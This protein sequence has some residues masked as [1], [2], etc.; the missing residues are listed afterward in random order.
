MANYNITS[1]IS[2]GTVI[3]GVVSGGQIIQ[4]DYHN[5]ANVSEP[6]TKSADEKVDCYPLNTDP[7]GHMLIIANEKYQ[8]GNH[9]PGALVDRKKVET[10]GETLNY[11]VESS[12]KNLTS[13]QI[14]QELKNFVEK[15]ETEPHVDSA[16]VFVL[17]HG[18]ADAIIGTDGVGVKRQEFFDAFKPDKCGAL[19][20]KP[21]LIF[22]DACR[23]HK[24]D[25]GAAIKEKSA[26][27]QERAADSETDGPYTPDERAAALAKSE[28]EKA[29]EETE[30]QEKVAATKGSRPSSP[31]P[32]F[33][34]MSDMLIVDA[35]AM[36]YYA[37]GTKSG[38][39][40]IDAVYEIFKLK[41]ETKSIDEMLHMVH[42]HVLKKMHGGKMGDGTY[43]LEGTN[44]SSSLRKIFMFCPP[45]TD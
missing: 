8:N 7:K 20:G 31:A 6:K 12:H 14:R 10:L 42:E 29:V 38:S 32:Q 22:F 18:T 19:T 41:Y 9:N 24:C 11:D 39:Y 1:N 17:S 4:G 3:S 33:S 36:D 26:G 45:A 34:A 43:A 15:L 40:F 5:Y 16:I 37:Y 13:E 44:Y 27:Q 21:K 23:G 25:P 2:G 28:I 35:T 30:T